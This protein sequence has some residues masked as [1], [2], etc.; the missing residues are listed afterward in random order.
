MRNTVTTEI[1]AGPAVGWV[2]AS[3]DA[4]QEQGHTVTRPDGA[5]PAR[6]DFTLANP[7]GRWTLRNPASPYYGQ[8]GRNSPAR[9]GVE[10]FREEFD[11]PT[12]AGSWGAGWINAWA[13]GVDD[14][15]SQFA[16]TGGAAVHRVPTSLASRQ[17][18]YEGR[19]FA[20]CEV[21][22]AFTIPALSG[23]TGGALEPANVMMRVQDI[24]VY[25]MARVEIT[26]A[27]A[28]QV[29]I[30]H[31]AA[32]VIA[33]AVVASAVLYAG[34]SW[35]V[36]ASCVGDRLAVSTWPTG[37]PEPR[38]WQLTATDTRISQPGY[39][40][41]RSGI[42]PGN[43]NAQPIEFRYSG[44]QVIDRRAVMEMSE[45]VPQ[46]N[47][48]GTDAWVSVTASGITRRLGQGAKPLDSALTRAIPSTGPAAWWPL[49]DQKDATRAASGVPGQ[50]ALN[51]PNAAAAGFG[52]DGPAGAAVAL[53]PRNGAVPALTA[54]PN[55]GIT[56]DS[57]AVSVWIRGA[58]D[59][60][61]KVGLAQPLGWSTAGEDWQV[62]ITSGR[63][64]VF[65]GVVD[66]DWYR[67]ELSKVTDSGTGGLPPFDVRVLD[68]QWHL[69]TIGL[70]Q[71]G[72][73]VAG[74]LYVDGTE[75]GAGW[76]TGT[77]LRAPEQLTLANGPAV[78]LADYGLSHLQ[79]HNGPF[80]PAEITAGA[81]YAGERAAD[82]FARLCAEQG[83]PAIISRGPELTQ[84]MGPQR[85]ATLLDLLR[86]CVDVDGGIMGEARE[87]LALTFVP[88]SVLYN[89][90]AV[91]LTFAHLAP[92]LTPVPGDRDVRNDVTVKR[93]GG[94][95]H[96]TVREDGPLG[97]A[98]VGVYDTSVTL[99]VESDG[100]LADAS[101]WR[102]H[103]GTWDEARYA[104]VRVNLAQPV[105]IGAAQL[106][107][108]VTA[109]DAGHVLELAQLPAHLSPSPV[110]LQVR[111]S[112][113]QLGQ[114]TR[115]IDFALQP[116]GPYTV[117]TVD[118]PQRAAADG[119][120]LA[121]ALGATATVLQLASTG[122]NGP[123]TE[124][125]ADTAVPLA[126]R[127]GGERV[128]VASI[129]AGALDDFEART[130]VDSWGADIN[131]NP[132]THAG[133]T[134]DNYGVS[135]GSARQVHTTVN[136]LRHSWIAPGGSRNYVMSADVML[137][138]MPAGAPVSVWAAARATD[139]G[140]YYAAQLAV[141]P[142][143]A[144]TLGLFRRQ[145]GALSGLAAMVPVGAHTAGAWW[146][147]EVSIS[148]D[149]LLARAW[150]RDTAPMPDWH[151]RANNGAIAA[152]PLVGI[153]SRLEAG[154]TGT[155]PATVF[156]DNVR[157][158]NPQRVVLAAR[159]VN[160]IQRAWPAGTDV[161]VW[162][163]AVAPL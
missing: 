22:T 29:S 116:A 111:G 109:L 112:V 76:I 5:D 99:P 143:G 90:A 139:T 120:V 57:F 4:R 6:W 72:A 129:T 78:N 104:T 21:R 45:P 160:G 33:S 50:P 12:L 122:P 119:S 141:A 39:V 159:G 42:G 8:L 44:L 84:R 88:V 162:N 113:E 163:P 94:A 127:V 30:H 28:V 156:V 121:A 1:Y 117:A 51:S 148:G 152:G 98:A 46:A 58:V 137:P 123:W 55:G 37:T 118:G 26:T 133:G 25:Y 74:W 124:A 101:G 61:T 43:T 70:Q 77:T 103:V 41:I 161:Q 106:A 107:D 23:V 69:L 13:G 27:E 110:A 19:T 100:Q 34:Q 125:A 134:P 146:R 97:T 115:S 105:W 91:P 80:S 48:A 96:R 89:R 136:A 135:G 17:T 75:R 16:R 3:A 93:T 32:G 14:N 83:V 157:V 108:S 7:D 64:D 2:D 54:A 92:P 154:Y 35:E 79:V 65:S 155:M 87:R 24:N 15:D 128:T 67:V 71:Q 52:G 142:G 132:W 81:G 18:H 63:E 38:D 151:V 102:V 49:E 20:D 9:L 126:V 85:P 68:G 10:M 47:T 131:G 138:V 95:S 140:T 53:A 158:A 147:V 66:P 36:V 150:L 130:T 59:D 145:S 82:R 40:G 62:F 73:D 144:T 31:S 11:G 149:G 56:P 153:L 86:E 60:P 114:Y